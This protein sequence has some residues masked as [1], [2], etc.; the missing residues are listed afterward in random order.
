MANMAAL[1]VIIT[2]HW[3]EPRS[4]DVRTPFLKSLVGDASR[5]PVLDTIAVCSYSALRTCIYCAAQAC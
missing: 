2:I 4:S 3:F 5:V 1:P